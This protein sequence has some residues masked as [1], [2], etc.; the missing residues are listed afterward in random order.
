M[1]FISALLV[2]MGGK[3]PQPHVLLWHCWYLVID[4]IESKGFAETVRNFPAHPLPLATET[5]IKK[6][7]LWIGT[8]TCL[9]KCLCT[10]SSG[11]SA[12]VHVLF[13]L[14]GF[15]DKPAG[16]TLFVRTADL[17]L[18]H[19]LATH[20]SDRCDNVLITVILPVKKHILFA[21]SAR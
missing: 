18:I 8:P 21:S 4:L 14:W 15:F 3:N 12:N 11:G 17:V 1:F 6:Q 13:R 2:I 20:L 19:G 5:T 9:S 7:E 10:P 16:F